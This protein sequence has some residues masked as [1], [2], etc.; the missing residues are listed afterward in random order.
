MSIQSLIDAYGRTLTRVRPTIGRD[1]AGAV[2]ASTTA[3]TCT[4][5]ITGYLQ[6]GAGASG[7]R[8]GRENTR[9]TATL[10]CL[11]ENADLKESDLV[12]VSINSQTRSYRV[13]SVVV[14]DDRPAGDPLRM[15]VAI[16]EE[17]L[18]RS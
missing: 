15:L 4:A 7:D 16:L 17:D 12:R 14:P 11:V 2:V 1:S 13:N 3:A 18:P 5:T 6:Q 10:Y 9:Y 8:Y